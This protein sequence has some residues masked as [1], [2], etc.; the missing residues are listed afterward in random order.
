M[1]RVLV[2]V[3]AISLAIFPAA[4]AQAPTSSVPEDLRAAGQAVVDY[5]KAIPDPIL[6][7]AYDTNRKINSS[8]AQLRDWIKEDRATIAKASQTLATLKLPLSKGA[9]LDVGFAL[10]R[11]RDGAKA[12]VVTAGV[13]VDSFE[14]MLAAM[15][16]GD[17]AGYAAKAEAYDKARRELRAFSTW[18][19]VEAIQAFVIRFAGFPPPDK[20]MQVKAIS[21]KKDLM[22]KLAG[23]LAA[24]LRCPMPAITFEME[25]EVPFLGSGG[26]G[27]GVHA[28]VRVTST[29]DP[30]RT[31]AIEALYKDFV[32]PEAYRFSGSSDFNGPLKF[33]WDGRVLSPAAE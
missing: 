6:Q 25:A 20:L 16:V 28:Y 18:E 9:G 22:L 5:A 19:D 1:N 21:S 4:V 14:A 32:V 29:T 26:T 8:D 15:R 7:V 30:T 13:V 3:C 23:D 17:C 31:A 11:M 2:A 12:N 33:N 10:K 24:P 27:N